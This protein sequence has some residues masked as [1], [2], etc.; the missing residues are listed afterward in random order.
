MHSPLHLLGMAAL[1]NKSF[2]AH[3]TEANPFLWMRLLATI[4]LN[5]TIMQPVCS[6]MSSSHQLMI[7]SSPLLQGLQGC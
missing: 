4:F 6:T 7:A 1:H 5:V 3:L 2:C